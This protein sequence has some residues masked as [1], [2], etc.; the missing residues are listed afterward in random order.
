MDAHKRASRAGAARRPS[1]KKRG[2]EELEQSL[3]RQSQGRAQASLRGVLCAAQELR[4][5]VRLVVV[6]HAVR[7][8][9]SLDAGYQSDALVAA[10]PV[11][12]ALVLVLF[13]VLLWMHPAAGPP[14]SVGQVSEDAWH[15]QG[16]PF[17][18]GDGAAWTHL[19]TDTPSAIVGAGVRVH[20]HRAGG[21]T[22]IIVSNDNV[23]AS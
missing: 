15:P 23:H 8:D 1:V 19:A 5:R 9:D 11:L 13:S 14:R 17:V 12:A 6:T 21:E 4:R 18:E 22:V 10:R 3:L 20:V 2:R 16:L 7:F